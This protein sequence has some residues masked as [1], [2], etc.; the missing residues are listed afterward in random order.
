MNKKN[1]YLAQP[2]YKSSN[3]VPFPAAIGALA[4][5]A[6]SLPEIDEAF[7]LRGILFLRDP[8]S[9]VVSEL[10]S[11]AVFGF[12][13]YMW[14]IEYN[15]A[16]AAL[17]K[18]RFPQCVILFGG[19]QVPEGPA[20]MED[21]PYIDV[22]IHGEGELPFAALLR[23]LNAGAPF[24]EIGGLS[25]RT[26]TGVV[27]V[28]AA[29]C[30]RVDFPSPVTS[31]FFDRLVREHPDLEFTPLIESSRG[32]PNHCAYC[33]WGN[34]ETGMRLF[35]LERVY[36]DLEWV[37]AH[38]MEYVGFADSNF[39][40][41]PRDEKITEK[42]LELHAATGYP[43]KFQVSYAKDSGDR[44]F[45][46]TQKLNEVGLCKGVTLSFQTMSPE[47]QKNIGRSNIDIEFYKQLLQKYAEA[48]IVTY[49]ELILGLPGETEESFV[50]GIEQLLEYGQHAQ[51]MIHLCEW[52][53]LSPMG[54]R[55]YLEKYGVKK[56]R[57]PLNQPHADLR[58]ADEIPEYSNVVTA[59]Y[60]MSEQTWKKVT[61]FGMCVL[62][63]HHLGLMQLPALYLYFE[64]GVKYVDF[65]KA[66]LS[67]FL[68]KGNS[69]FNRITAQL[70]GIVAGA[71]GA[72][73]TDDRFGHVSWTFEEYAFL[74]AVYQKEAFYRE[75]E[76]FLAPFIPD[77]AFRAEMLRYQS[78][79]V[80][81]I[82]RP[83]AEFTGN[84]AW[85]DYLGTLQ[86]NRRAE[87]VARPVRYAVNDAA[88]CASWP[89]Y[90]QKVVWY[91]RRGGKN[92][93]AGNEIKELPYDG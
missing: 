87:L 54:E 71:A 26:E 29:P 70:D 6:W 78:F 72:V 27:T 75:M 25:Y 80:K 12:S 50:G 69:V 15:K 83:H 4:A 7:R 34:K 47:A 79:L 22:L 55:E 81:E 86:R 41:F 56:V 5:Y 33:S 65:Y 44:V 67:H 82:C 93:Y 64:K 63:F 68:A 91:G 59:T 49:S 74:S 40:M 35:P 10:E 18:K 84:Y 39:G 24:G 21:C 20:L 52:L 51:M 11:P 57:I 43:K 37:C 13:C 76:A 48:G 17:V 9:E 88:V 77:A 92:L 58:A 14:N 28:P 2:S 1:V 73:V 36:A 38:K 85:R 32:C 19:P 66:L 3:S 16:L 31:G 89:E 30:C 45:R 42:L 90:A 46:I 61:L 60:S 62:C 8:L 53:P 23:A